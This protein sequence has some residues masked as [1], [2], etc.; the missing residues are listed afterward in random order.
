MPSELDRLYW[1]HKPAQGNGSNIELVCSGLHEYPGPSP[2]CHIRARTS[3][4]SYPHGM[5]A[6]SCSVSHMKPV[7]TLVQP[8]SHAECI[9]DP[10]PPAAFTRSVPHTMCMG[11][12]LHTTY[13]TCGFSPRPMH[14]T[15]GWLIN[16]YRL[17]IRGVPS[18][19]YSIWIRPNLG[20]SNSIN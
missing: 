17:D 7:L 11:L 6:R 4:V 15:A 3:L 20:D 1:G 12:V 18:R 8:R 16:L 10:A 19:L 14:H 9:L 2:A 5:H 13:A